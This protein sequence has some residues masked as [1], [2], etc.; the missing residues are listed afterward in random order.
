MLTLEY[1]EKYHQNDTGG[2]M[3]RLY[4]F[5]KDKPELFKKTGKCKGEWKKKLVEN[6]FVRRLNRQECEVEEYIEDCLHLGID[7]LSY[8]G[9]RITDEQIKEAT[10]E[11]NIYLKDP[12]NYKLY[13]T[14]K[15]RTWWL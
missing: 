1:L 2:N 6:L 14:F 10:K 3:T 8:Y 12:K 11:Y 7:D 9:L 15:F 5:L 4:E 13:D